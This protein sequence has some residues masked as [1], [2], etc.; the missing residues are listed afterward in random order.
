MRSRFVRCAV[1]FAVFALV[2][3]GCT[4]GV[5]NPADQVTAH[6][7]N[8]HGAVLSTR[9]ETGS[10][11]FDV[12]RVG[13]AYGPPSL[14]SVAFTS[15]TLIPVSLTQNG[16]VPGTDYRY[17]VCSKDSDTTAP[18]CGETKF[19][20]TPA[21]PTAAVSLGDSYISGEGGRWRATRSTSPATATAPIARTRARA[22]STTR[23]WPTTRRRT[24]TGAIAPP[25]PR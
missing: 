11:W 5:T 10:Y 25:W 7:A 24:R 12:A 15:K 4:I 18:G 16:L 22:R 20:S 19:F 6:K 23:A 9:D 17:R 1:L 14:H 3:T 8:L 2:L 13:E 21:A